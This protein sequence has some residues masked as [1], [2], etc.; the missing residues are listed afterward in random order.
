M[1]LTTLNSKFK[2]SILAGLLILT[3]TLF[4][5]CNGE[6]GSGPSIEIPGMENLQAN[7]YDD[8]MTISM[9]LENIDIVVGGRIPILDDSGSYVDLAPHLQ[10]QG[11]LM[12]FHVKMG[13]IT[14]DNDLIHPSTLPGGRPIPGVASGRLPAAAVT[15][16]EVADMTFY[17]G[18]D[19]FGF[20]LPLDIGLQGAIITGRFN[21]GGNTVGNVSLVG[22]DESGQHG[23]VLLLIDLKS[24]VNGRQIKRF[25]KQKVRQYN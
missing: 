18:L 10:G 24:K 22:D 9:H 5:S 8:Y 19:V 14:G 23:G 4:V 1:K 2:K 15:V 3:T 11:T 25:M 16:D 7:F 21:F 6:D 12:T 13:T 20:H 17:L